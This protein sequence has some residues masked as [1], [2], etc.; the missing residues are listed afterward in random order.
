MENAKLFCGIP[1]KGTADFANIVMFCEEYS[2]FVLAATHFTFAEIAAAA[3]FQAAL[4]FVRSHGGSNNLYI[5]KTV[6]AFCHWSSLDAEDAAAI[7]NVLTRMADI[8]SEVDVPSAYGVFQ[9]I[10][11]VAIDA[12]LKSGVSGRKIACAFGGTERGIQKNRKRLRLVGSCSG[13]GS[14]TTKGI[15]PPR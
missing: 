5:H 3:G 7:W 8:D 15:P 13:G 4:E 2:S 11:R 1:A 9:A 14:P 10:R 6:E 12:A